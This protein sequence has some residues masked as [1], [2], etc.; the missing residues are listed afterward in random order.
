MKAWFVMVG[1]DWGEYVHGETASKAKSMFW[2]SWSYEAEEWIYLRA[3]RVPELD[4]IPI[5]TKNINNIRE[6]NELWHPICDCP[7]CEKHY[8]FL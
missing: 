7:I 1:D 4:D 2:K 5:T 8:R 3:Y 6:D